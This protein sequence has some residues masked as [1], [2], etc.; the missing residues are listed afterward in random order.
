MDVTGWPLTV[1]T[2]SDACPASVSEATL[3]IRPLSA[4]RSESDGTF[5]VS[6]RLI[7]EV[8]FGLALAVDG[9]KPSGFFLCGLFDTLAKAGSCEGFART[10]QAFKTSDSV[11]EME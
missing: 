2:D 11:T 9:E 1:G 10:L 5:S 6:P 8:L 3:A 7:L 4:I